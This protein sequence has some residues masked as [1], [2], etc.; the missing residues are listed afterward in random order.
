MDRIALKKI[1]F[2]TLLFFILN[3]FFLYSQEINTSLPFND[4][5]QKLI[6]NLSLS[7]DIVPIGSET[8]FTVTLDIKKGYHI[9]SYTPTLDY[10]IPTT[11]EFDKIEG[12]TAEQIKYPSALLKSFDFAEKSILVYEGKIKI[13]G[14][15]KISSDTKIGNYLIKG[16]VKYQACTDTQCFRPEE[17]SLNAKLNVVKKL[18]T[19]QNEEPEVIPAESTPIAIETLAKSPQQTEPP[20][21]TEKI[22]NWIVQKG[23]LVTFI[24]IFFMGIVLNFTPCVFPIIPLTIGYFVSQSEDKTIKIFFLSLLYVL[25]IAIMYSILGV[26]AGITGTLFGSALSNPIILILISLVI[27]ILALSLFDLYELKPPAFLM[28]KAESKRGFF[29][30]FFMGLIVGIVAAPC[31]GPVILSLLIFVGKQGNPIL[32]FW[33]FFILA[34]GMGL[35]YIFLGV[36]TGKLK[37]LPKAGD[38]MIGIRRIFGLILLWL[39]LYFLKPVFHNNLQIYRA[40]EALLLL[41]G[42]I[43]LIEYEKSGKKLK[44]FYLAKKLIGFFAFIYVIYAFLITKSL[45]EAN[46]KPYSE[47]VYSKAIIDKQKI[48]I[49]FYAT[50]CA[51]CIKLEEETFSNPDVVKELSNYLLLKVDLTSHN[52]PESTKQLIKKFDVKGV[53]WIVFIDSNGKERTDLRITEFIKSAKFLKT[54]ERFK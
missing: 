26:I 47:E 14:K 32:G 45:S 34:I 44:P 4:E 39:A 31:I 20:E 40:L 33:M 11:I 27:V 38:W 16:K 24:L 36:F 7:Q 50:W 21:E 30:A 41:G 10:L 1:I 48:I 6:A 19:I 3:I 28:K 52:L 54:L 42:G 9:N 29:G 25:G 17:I 13:S 53:P 12:I 8:D 22:S 15:L 49:D 35:P 37:S 18:E 5:L 51:P 43:Y 2:L 23:Y 46:W